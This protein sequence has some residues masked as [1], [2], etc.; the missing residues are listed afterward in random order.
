VYF[1]LKGDTNKTYDSNPNNQKKYNVI[2]RA[3]LMNDLKQ[4]FFI[5]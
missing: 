1:F 4:G 2:A 3:F 5:D